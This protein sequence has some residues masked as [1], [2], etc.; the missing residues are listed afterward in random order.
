VK[1]A[2]YSRIAPLFDQNPG[3]RRQGEPDQFLGERL[4]V[5]A[6]RPFV[7]LDIGCGTGTYLA[8][9]RAA[10]PY[11]AIRWLGVDRSPAML[12]R[13]RPKAPGAPLA[14][15]AAERLPLAGGIADYVVSTFTLHHFED[16]GEALDEIRRVSRPGGAL[17]LMNIVPEAMPGWWVYRF[18][19]ET[20]EIDAERFWPVD[21]VRRELEL[22]DW[23]VDLEVQRMPL[24][25]AL[26]D[27][28]LEA[29][30]RDISQLDVLDDRDY[31]R[32]LDRLRAALA[33]GPGA[34]VDGESAVVL[35]RAVIG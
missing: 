35:C 6:R 23:R 5:V 30:R 27:L 24:R 4:A 16:K 15:G 2:D 14:V 34:S 13:A 12:A 3:R 31:G 11:Q 17:R 9:Q 19:P 7:V 21:R 20:R 18:F 32:G 26:R 33:A 25:H 29:K 28:L 1:R 8:A 10:Y 22:R